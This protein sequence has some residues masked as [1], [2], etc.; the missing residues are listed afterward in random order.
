MLP[1]EENQTKNKR[2]NL[3]LATRN[4]RDYWKVMQIQSKTQ[5]NENNYCQH[6]LQAM[7]VL[8][9]I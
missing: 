9:L 4:W 3:C 5:L 6:T 7:W 1:F 2:K 8:G